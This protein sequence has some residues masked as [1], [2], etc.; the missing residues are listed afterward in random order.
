MSKHLTPQQWAEQFSEAWRALCEGRAAVMPIDL[1]RKDPRTNLPDRT[2]GSKLWL[3]L[4]QK[5]RKRKG[6]QP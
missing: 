5:Q 6:M 2:E 1:R 3:R 4:D